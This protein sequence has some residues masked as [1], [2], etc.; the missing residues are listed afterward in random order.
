LKNLRKTR[1][2][3]VTSKRWGQSA[4][5]RPRAS[6]RAPCAPSQGRLVPSQHS[7]PRDPWV[8][9]CALRRFPAHAG[10]TG[11]T[12]SDRQPP[13]CPSLRVEPRLLSRRP[14]SSTHATY[15][16][17]VTPPHAQ[18]TPRPCRAALP[19]PLARPRRTPPCAL[20]LSWDRHQTCSPDCGRASR[21]AHSFALAATSPE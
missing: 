9:C 13:R 18:A 4:P 11:R 3:R 16:R 2:N 17:S 5:R 12:A 20:S 19:S 1:S 15:K 6:A 14:S 7:A 21:A 10:P 8:L